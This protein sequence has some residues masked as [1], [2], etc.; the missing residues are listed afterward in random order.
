ML[1][2]NFAK[3]NE[4]I[5]VSGGCSGRSFEAD[6]IGGGIGGVGCGVSIYLFLSLAGR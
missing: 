1:I 5:C 6:G 2:Y 3:L 4:S